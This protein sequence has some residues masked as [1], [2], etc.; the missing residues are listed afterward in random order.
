MK[1]EYKTIIKKI[2]FYHILILGCLLCPLLISNSNRVNRQRAE[3]KLNEE[4]SRLFNKII[5]GRYLEGEEKEKEKEKEEEEEEKS[6]GTEEVCK[7]GSDELNNYYK[8]GNLDE[9]KLKDGPI[10]SEDKDKDYMKALINIIKTYMKGDGNEDDDKKSESPQN[11]GATEGEGGRRNLNEDEAQKNDKKG[12]GEESEIPT[13]D[14]IAYGKHLLPV[15]IFLVVA[16]LCIPGWLM[17][18]FCCCCNCCCCC[19]C[20]KPCCKIPC[21][22]ITYALYALVVAVCIYG[23][24]QSNH[25]FV[26]IADTECSILRFFDEI[27][28]GEIKTEKPRWAGFTGI[29]KILDDMSTEI[30]SM[31]STTKGELDNEMEYIK[32]NKTSF[33]ETMTTIWKRFTESTAIPPDSYKNIYSKGYT[34]L[35]SDKN[36]NYVLDLIKYFGYYDSSQKKFLPPESTLAIWEME[37]KEVSK[38]ADDNME[39]AHSGFTELLDG[40]IQDITKPLDEGKEMVGNITET[41]NGIKSTIADMIVDNS[42]TID[43][44][45]KLGIKAVFGVLALLNVAI[46]AFMLLLCF[47][48]GKCCTKCCC[49]RC[50]CKLFT[51]ILWNILALLMIIVFLVG[52]LFALIGKVGSDAMSV[53]SYVV[54]DDNIGEGGDGVLLDQIEEYKNYTTRCIGGDGKI[55]EELG[56][57]LDQI[58]S[59]N[60]I[61]DAENQI[62]DAKREFNEKKDFITYNIYMNKLKERVDLTDDQLSLLPVNGNIDYALNFNLLLGQINGKSLSSHNEKWQ[63]KDSGEETCES[64]ADGIP[65][66]SDRNI[67]FHPKK[68]KPSDRDWIA[69]ISTDDVNIDVKNNAE[70]ISDILTFVDNAG[71]TG[72]EE[73]YKQTLT[74]L[75]D[76]YNVYLTSYINALDKFNSTIHR[77]TGKLDEYTG[78]AGAFSFANCNFI[79]TNLKVILKYLNE[80][81]GG[82]IYTIGVCL[83]LVGCSLALSISFTILL[84]IVINANIDAN[85][86]KK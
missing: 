27:L 70:K 85:K 55:E 67:I 43:E 3:E 60:N 51:H 34:N 54:S 53:I 15:L 21:F 9:I 42:E 40:N 23:I 44:Y 32:N 39:Q 22:V 61:S 62:R 6:N 41:F 10:K 81:F 8:T 59:I 50:I 65:A 30:T 66:H 63:V 25:I 2:K 73:Y 82:D 47:C 76:K 48:S 17:C 24:S 84:I 74:D 52:S 31:G 11:A 28:E 26:G 12:E 71:K 14:I 19:C 68:C 18:C 78:G 20:K 49:C 86:S 46:A 75:R 45:G 56:L 35:G 64:G 7:R 13:D 57:D 1:S 29:I 80:V 37:Y 36:G 5:S 16:I 77:I 83:I 72:N 79:G 69:A 38:V 58:N 4:K 33:Q